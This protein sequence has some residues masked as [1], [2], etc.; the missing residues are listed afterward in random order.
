MKV[1]RKG[2]GEKP[3]VISLEN[4]LSAL[5]KAVGGYIES[6]TFCANAAIL[7]NEEGRLLGLAHNCRVLGI[8]FV[9]T[10]LVVGVEGCE[11]RS[12][13]EKEAAFVL[14]MLSEEES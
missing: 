14:R 3:R 5:Q 10:I 8:D 1:V 6:V 9:G 7:C 2:P 11:M 12:L 13:T 4:T